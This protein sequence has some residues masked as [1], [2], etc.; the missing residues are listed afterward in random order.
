MADPLLA[1]GPLVNAADV[2][3]SLVVIVRGVVPFVEKARRAQ[4]A[5]AQAVL[6][7]NTDDKAYV[8]LG[9]T[10]DEDITIPV[11]CVTA[12]D[13]EA[14]QA[15]LAK[16]PRSTTA[17]LSYGDAP[18]LPAGP[19][20]MLAG[21]YESCIRETKMA[22]EE[23]DWE[24]AAMHVKRHLEFKQMQQD[25][26]MTEAEV[27]V[28]EQEQVLAMGEV[29]KDLEIKLVQSLIVD[30]AAV[31]EADNIAQMHQQLQLLKELGHAKQCV[32]VYSAHMSQVAALNFEKMQSVRHFSL[33]HSHFNFTHR[34]T[35]PFSFAQ[36]LHP[37]RHI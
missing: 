6:F 8:P 4:Q 32:G 26:L 16:Y 5:G 30:F 15:V 14:I 33:Q 20:K 21:F 10:G 37:Y 24:G 29:M 7:I 25:G 1:D 11:A 28:M 22:M 36:L 17:S 34:C 12:S 27:A 19:E 2:D 13:G 31:V 3:G 35:V 9:M 23:K 18:M